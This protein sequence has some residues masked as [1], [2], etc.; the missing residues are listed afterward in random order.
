MKNLASVIYEDKGLK[1]KAFD[2]N[3]DI[4]SRLKRPR[5][6]DPFID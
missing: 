4:H 3:V 6:C 2:K 1:K 5:L